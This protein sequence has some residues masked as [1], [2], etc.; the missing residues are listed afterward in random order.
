[1]RRSILLSLGLVAMLCATLVHADRYLTLNTP[2]GQFTGY[3]TSMTWAF[4]GI[5]FAKPPVGDLRWKAPVK[6]DYVTALNATNDGPACPQQCVC[7]VGSIFIVADYFIR[8]CCGILR[9]LT[10]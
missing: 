5:P 1:M 6:A 3:N 2:A 9:Y 10:S 8:L 4:R 7:L